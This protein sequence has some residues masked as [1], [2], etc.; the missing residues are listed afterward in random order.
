MLRYV[1]KKLAIAIPL[2]LVV[3]MV[4]FAL[5]RLAPSD[6]VSLIVP[7]TA[8]K[9]VKDQVRSRLHLD[10]P[11]IVQYGYFIADALRGDFG[12]SYILQRDVSELIGE[13][14]LNTLKLGLTGLLIAY[15]IA[16]PI[17]VV[18]ATRHRTWVDHF[19][20]AL[21][22]AGQC[23]PSFVVSLLLIL[24]FA[25]KFKLFPT[26]GYTSWKNLV[27]PATALAFE[28]LT[29]SVRIMRSSM[30]EVLGMDYIRT[31]RAKGLPERLVIWQHALKNSLISVISVFA[32]E[33]GWLFAG[34]V[35]IEVVFAWPG[36]GRLLVDAV[37]RR[38]YPLIQ[39]LTLILAAG[40]ILANLL[41]DVLYAAVN[42]RIRY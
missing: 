24:V 2:L 5:I 11:L 41:A 1:A 33:L 22:Y 31:L 7:V 28:S 14:L 12:R 4:V 13:R 29:V 9:E 26:S 27:L 38:D 36:A 18:A 8:S 32:L 16:I 3:S 34:A 30:L 40:V 6:P 20:V 15:S 17:G 37:S 39:G 10:E 23:V 42:P 25:Y 19:S 21:A 35:A